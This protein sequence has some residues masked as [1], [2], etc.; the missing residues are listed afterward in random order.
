MVFLH[1]IPLNGSPPPAPS[2]SIRRL[3]R[4]ICFLTCRAFVRVTVWGFVT[5]HDWKSCSW[6]DNIRWNC[7]LCSAIPK[8]PVLGLHRWRAPDTMLVQTQLRSPT[9]MSSWNAT[10]LARLCFLFSLL[11]SCD[12]GGCLRH[13]PAG[14][15]AGQDALV[16]TG[17][18]RAVVDAL[19]RQNRS[20]GAQREVR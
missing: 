11:H 19:Q 18:S 9:Q 4:M 7:G 10:R 5:K 13:G 8:H 20:R 17:Q 2:W 16:R 3:G 6:L 12:T 14:G 15:R 1:G